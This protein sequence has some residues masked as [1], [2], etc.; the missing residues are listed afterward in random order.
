M[1][2]KFRFC[3]GHSIVQSDD[4]GG[5]R[6]LPRTISRIDSFLSFVKFAQPSILHQLHWFEF[7]VDEVDFMSY[8]RS[9]D[10]V[11]RS[12]SRPYDDVVGISQICG[13]RQYRCVL[14]SRNSG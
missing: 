3:K 13:L 14:A 4:A 8:F 1:V 5:F 7:K 12:V 11:R 2:G 9:M 10:L 6:V